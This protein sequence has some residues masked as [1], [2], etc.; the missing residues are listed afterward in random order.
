MRTASWRVRV[1]ILDGSNQ[2]QRIGKVLFDYLFGNFTAYL[3]GSLVTLLPN[4]HLQ[5]DLNQNLG[6]PKLGYL[7]MLDIY[8]LGSFCLLSLAAF[9]ITLLDEETLQ[10]THATA[11]P[12]PSFFQGYVSL[13]LF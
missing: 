5:M 12:L 13:W 6:L 3:F 8:I 1:E 4:Y 9:V 2:N 11:V 10:A 7:T